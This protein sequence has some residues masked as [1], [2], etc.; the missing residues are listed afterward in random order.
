MA[1]GVG[2]RF[3]PSSTEENPKQFLDILGTGK[4]L[5]QQ[6]VDRFVPIVGQENILILTNSQYKELVC[7]QLPNINEAQ[8]ICEPARRNTAPCI[9]YAAFKIWKKTPDASFIVAPSD[10]LISKESAFAEAIKLG[11]EQ[12]NNDTEQIVTLGIKPTYPSTGF[13]YIHS[14]SELESGVFKVKAFTE[15]PEL[16]K[17]QTM[18]SSGNYYWNSGLFIWNAKNIINLFENYQPEMHQLFESHK[19]KLNTT[20]EANSVQEFYPLCNDISVDYA[21]L[22]NAKNVTVIPGDFGWSDL[23]SWSSLREHVAKDE[24]ENILVNNNTALLKESAHNI[25][26]IPKNKKAIIKALEGY[27]I[28]DTEEALLICPIKDEQKIKQYVAELNSKK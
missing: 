23:G 17:A 27:I 24:S 12:C 13:G 22:E 6:T 21:I 20:E 4:S 2:S 5:L 9:L 18:C 11:L 14:G 16:E 1:G 25:V 10:H 3:W 7:T 28:V 26:V 8:V 19:S 15:K